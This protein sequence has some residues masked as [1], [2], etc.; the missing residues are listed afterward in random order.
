M[1]KLTS[2]ATAMAI[3]AL[4]LPMQASAADTA[5]KPMTKTEAPK[6]AAATTP[7]AKVATTV[8]KKHYAKRHRHHRLALHKRHHHRLAAHTKRHRHVAA[9]KTHKQMRQVKRHRSHVVQKS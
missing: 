4:A 5:T 9:H 6:T 8:K 2:L 1:R 7:K 3:L